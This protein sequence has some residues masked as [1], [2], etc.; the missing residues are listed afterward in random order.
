M[1][2]SKVLLIDDNIQQHELFNCYAASAEKIELK[3]AVDIDQGMVSMMDKQPDVI[4][5]DNHLEFDETYKDSVPRLRAFGYTGP[6]VVI[7]SDISN[8][9]QDELEDYSVTNCAG[10]LDFDRNNFENKIYELMAA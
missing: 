8:L 10:K 1:P 6:I 3:S 4:L 7:S 5:L 2:G 9:S